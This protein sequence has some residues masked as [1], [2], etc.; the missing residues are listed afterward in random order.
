MKNKHFILIMTI[1]ILLIGLSTYKSIEV[2]ADSGFDTSYSSGGSSSSSHSSSGFSSSSSYSSSSYWGSSNYERRDPESWE[3]ISALIV[4]IVGIIIV[5]KKAGFKKE[6]FI[7]IKEAS[8]KYAEEYKN[9]QKYAGE[10]RKEKQKLI[11]KHIKTDI[12]VFLNDRY[13]DY[14]KV[15]EDWMNFNYE[16]LREILTDELYNQYKMQL[17]TLK[18]KNQKNV[19]KRFKYIGSYILDIYEE[20]ERVVIIVELIVSFVDYIEQN[21]KVVR[22]KRFKKITHDYLLHFIKNTKTIDKCPNCGA[23]I[24]D[25]KCKY[26]GSIIPTANN[27]WLLSKKKSLKQK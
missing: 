7:K 24:E 21:G 3:I 19:M 25:N 4:L 23:K 27:K 6:D 15:Q 1:G 12:N 11:E 10:Q 26:C 22:G 14:L 8:E 16:G 9:A 20:S 17:E 13:L 2:K 5:F 18:E